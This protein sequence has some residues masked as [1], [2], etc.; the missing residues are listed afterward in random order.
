[1]TSD[2]VSGN[3][4][5]GGA[6]EIHGDSMKRQKGNIKKDAHKAKCRNSTEENRHKSMMNRAK[7]AA[8]KAMTDKTEKE[9]TWSK[10]CP[11]GMS[12]LVK[13]LKT[14]SK[15]VEEGRCKR[16]SDGK[17]YLSEKERGKVWKDYMERNMHEENDWDHN[18]DGD[19]VEGPVVCVSREEMLQALN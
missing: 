4:M 6:K 15:E 1:M 17:L 14:D 13:G 18:V 8:S 7:K 2:E 10:N 5:V 19:A 16:G 9:L 12:R 11:N 3:K